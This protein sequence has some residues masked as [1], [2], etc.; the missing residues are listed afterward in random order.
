MCVQ[1]LHDHL[2]LLIDVIDV[3]KDQLL[4]A[5]YLKEEDPKYFISSKTGR[6]PLEDNWREAYWKECKV[7]PTS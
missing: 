5:D 7:C 1:C 3:V 6:G 2:I 4:G